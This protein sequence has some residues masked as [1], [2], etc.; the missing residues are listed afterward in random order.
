MRLIAMDHIGLGVSDQADFEMLDMHHTANLKQ[1]IDHLELTNVTLVVHDWG[2]PIGIAAFLQTPE[3]V[4]ALLVM[5]TTVFPMP[6]EGHTYTNFPFPWL[7]WYLTA[8]LIPDALWGGVAAA[9]VSHAHP[10]G[11][12]QFLA[13]TGKYLALHALRAIP[14]EAPEYV[15]SQMLRGKANARSSKRNVRQTP[16]WGYGYRYRDRKHGM[17]DNHAYHANIQRQLKPLWGPA[18]QNIAVSGFFGQ[19]D[20]CGK[21]SVIQQ[22]LEALPQMH[23]ACYRFP[24]VGHFIEEYKGPEMAAAILRMN[25]D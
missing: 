15:W 18:G 23:D 8:P 25:A 1:L 14:E 19:W 17:Q 9:V 16:V 21:D 20:A 7:P 5:N 13:T 12:A 4:K 6:A 2:G 11:T 24:D 10:Q 22:W 3:L